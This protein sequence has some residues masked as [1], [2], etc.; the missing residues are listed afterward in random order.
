LTYI[1]GLIATP[2]Q[3]MVRAG[4]LALGH[5]KIIAG[6]AEPAEQQR[7]ADLVQS[8]GLSVRNLERIIAD[9]D[10]FP[11]AETE[12]VDMGTLDGGEE[13]PPVDPLPG[14]EGTPEHP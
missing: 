2:I 8:Q 3:V 12:A 13:F 4:T 6:I 11:I 5:A 1:N 7:L 14:G 10:F 9:S